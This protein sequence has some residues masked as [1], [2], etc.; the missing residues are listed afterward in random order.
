MA[1]IFTLYRSETGFKVLLSA[2]LL[3]IVGVLMMILTN[4]G[5]F[6]QL[7]PGDIFG[8]GLNDKRMD[9]K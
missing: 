1:N 5:A 8:E 3:V 7:R 6:V 9:E 4:R 2:A